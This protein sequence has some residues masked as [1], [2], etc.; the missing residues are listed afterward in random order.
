MHVLSPLGPL[1]QDAGL[2]ELRALGFLRRSSRAALLRASSAFKESPFLSRTRWRSLQG[3]AAV[4]CTLLLPP[5]RW[6]GKFQSLGQVFKLRLVNLVVI[7]LFDW[8]R[9]RRWD[10]ERSCRV[11]SKGEFVMWVA[12]ESQRLLMKTC[13]RYHL[14]S[15]INYPRGYIYIYISSSSNLLYIQE[16]YSNY[17][18]YIL[19]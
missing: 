19:S 3:G 9:W 17:K 1:D 8:S 12:L 13:T 18:S 7:N 14:S 5:Q 16:I 11:R 4:G 10:Q 15:S 2:H 6:S